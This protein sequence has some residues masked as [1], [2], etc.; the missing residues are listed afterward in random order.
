MKIEFRKTVCLAKAI[1]VTFLRG[2]VRTLYGSLISG[3]I[4][5]SIYGFIAIKSETGY[6]AVFD[7]ITACATLAV[8]LS[9]LYV[10]GCKK[11]GKRGKA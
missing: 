7:F 5:I 2:L 10:M 6:I 4:G 1:G 8:G 3:L 9:N 11:H